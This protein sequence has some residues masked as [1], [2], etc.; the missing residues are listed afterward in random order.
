MPNDQNFLARAQPWWHRAPVYKK[1]KWIPI[2]KQAKAPLFK[3]PA[4][5]LISGVIVQS[6]LGGLL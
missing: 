6:S 5:F 2:E 3:F 4:V 1:L